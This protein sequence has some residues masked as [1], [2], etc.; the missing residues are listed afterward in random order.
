MNDP[1]PVRITFEHGSAAAV[2]RKFI[3]GFF[4]FAML[5]AGAAFYRPA[6][7]AFAIG[8]P[9]YLVLWKLRLRNASR[10]GWALVVSEDR[11]CLEGGGGPAEVRRD[12][13]DS[14]RFTPKRLFLV[15]DSAQNPIFK[16]EI[17]D[18]D[19]DAIDAALS[20]KGWPVG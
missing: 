9:V 19:R 20:A 10:P 3:G 18:T 12:E 8:F 11:I 4:A 5:F 13:A 17:D 16:V 15:L 6:I 7:Q 14:I 1:A 2:K